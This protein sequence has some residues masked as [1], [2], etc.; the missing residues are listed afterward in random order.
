MKKI[1]AAIIT[2]SLFASAAYANSAA[3]DGH[4]K[5]TPHHW[6]SKNKT[7]VITIERSYDSATDY[8][9]EIYVGEGSYGDTP[10]TGINILQGCGSIK[11]IAV[12]SSAVCKLSMLNPMIRFSSDSD[13]LTAYGAY[14]IEK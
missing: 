13:S 6:H 3:T 4:A 9:V 5:F 12:Q 2:T 10:P 14:H 1:I 7:D 11:H 8:S